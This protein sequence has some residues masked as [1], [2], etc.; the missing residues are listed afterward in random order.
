MIFARRSFFTLILTAACLTLV[1]AE[2]AAKALA[3][4]WKT[5][6]ADG[7]DA[8]WTFDGDKLKASVNGNDYKAEFKVDEKAKPNATMDVTITESPD[9]DGGKKVG[10]AIYKLDGKKLTICV[11]MPGNDRPS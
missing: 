10:K 1:H 3:G 7:I 6:G 11:A 2:D 9:G 5:D 4:T 8:T